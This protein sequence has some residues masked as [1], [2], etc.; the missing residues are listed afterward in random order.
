MAETLTTAAAAIGANDMTISVTSATGFA[1]GNVIRVDNEWMVQTAAASGVVVPVR[2]GLQGSAQV[3]HNLL[4]DV[5]TGLPVDFQTPPPGQNVPQPPSGDGMVTYG[6]SGAI[7]IPQKDSTIILQKASAAA[8]TLA[9]PAVG[10]DGL[11]LTILA[12]TA[13]AHTVSNL[14]GSGFNGGGTGSDIGTFG[15]AIGDGMIIKA[16][17]GKWIV[18]TKTNVTLAAWLLFAFGSV[19]GAAFPGLV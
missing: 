12:T 3:A 17:G 5:A 4:S 10:V 18:V 8:M 11:T 6:A 14:G 1:A 19:L 16:E 15:G 13:A 9:D 2:R 7:A